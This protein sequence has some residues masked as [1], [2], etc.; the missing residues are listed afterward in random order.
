MKKR[1]LLTGIAL[2]LFAALA[3]N[4]LAPDAIESAPVYII[5][6]VEIVPTH[7]SLPASEAEVPR[8]SLDRAIVAFTAGE[9][10]FM[11]VRS[12]QSHATSHIAGAVSIPL[13]NIEIGVSN[14][15]LKKDQ[16]IIT[17]CT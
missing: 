9:A 17:Y 13:T 7:T 10:V 1:N 3:C 4:L 11:D 6:E 8:I 14:L 15:S 5:T 2:L 16:W 12:A